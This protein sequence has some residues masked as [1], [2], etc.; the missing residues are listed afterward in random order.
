MIEQEKHLQQ[1]S[2]DTLNLFQKVSD[3]VS[4]KIPTSPSHSSDALAYSNEFT[5]KA[6]GRLS[7][8]SDANSAVLKKLKI[9]PA[10]SRVIFED[11][12]G[13]QH[14]VYITRVSTAGVRVGATLTSKNSKL[15]ALSSV[16][17][18]DAEF[19][20][21]QGKV[22]E[23]IVVESINLIPTQPEGIWD[24]QNSTYRH[25]E[26]GTLSIKSLR[27][28]LQNSKLKDMDELEAL[29][30]GDVAEDN[31][32]QGVAHQIRTAMG[33]RD[34]PIL[35]KF[36]SSIFRQ[37][38]NSQKIILGPPGTGKTT[39]LIQR[40]GQ[41]VDR[42]YL[43]PSEEN[44]ANNDFSG[45][46]HEQSWLMF[47]PTDLL[48][49]YVKE[50]FAREQ[51]PASNERI[52]TWNS[53]RDDIARNVFD[54]LVF[55]TDKG[56]FKKKEHLSLLNPNT[57]ANPVEWFEQLEK[58]HNTR[59]SKQLN[60]GLEQL[61]NIKNKKVESTVEQ[62]H[63][64]VLNSEPMNLA[65]T[66]SSLI[67]LEEKL[68]TIVDSESLRIEK[69]IKSTISTLY[70]NDKSILADLAKFF[71][72][73]STIDD[74]EG[75]E[76]DDDPTEQK[77]ISKHTPATAAKEYSKIIKSIARQ[78]YL[79]RSLSK[80]SRG[81]LVKEW[82]GSRL[83]SDDKLV[84][85]G[86]VVTFQNSLR[87]FISAHRRFITEIAASYKLFRK[88]SY[89]NNEFYLSVP[90]VNKDISH[91]E[92]DGVILQTL[93]NIHK[94]LK[95]K[96]FRINIE[97]PSF[98]YLKRR[99][100]V[101]KNQILV[102]EATDFSII[103]LACMKHLSHVDTQSFF[104]CGDFNQRL[105]S[106]GVHS[107]EQLKWIIP[108]TDIEII[109]AAYRQSRKLNEFAK[110][111]LIA[112][113]G[114]VSALGQIPEESN[115]NGVD[116][117]L[118][119]GYSNIT[120]V[121]KWLSERIIEIH[122]TVNSSISQEAVIVPTIAI[123]VNDESNVTLLADSLNPYLEEVSLTAEAC[124]DG[125]SLGEYQG[126]RVFSVE[127]IKGLE[128][129]AVFFIDVDELAN[130]HPDTFDK[131]LYV[132]VTRAAT[133]LGMTCKKELPIEISSLRGLLK[134]TF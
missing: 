64:I 131:F 42:E 81:F 43:E 21:F 39:T 37:P 127:H 134:A 19:I 48:K 77:T 98:S 88:E 47:T 54:L 66:Y 60:D 97:N 68:K 108:E 52:R 35:D 17:I 115:H 20:E 89:V 118:Y 106:S 94:L 45:L 75:D 82:L 5:D 111:L 32:E 53:V 123:L 24:S 12:K 129:E 36:Q 50:A 86:Q 103:Q 107:Q 63:R 73:L 14:T 125:K 130:Y 22:Q 67:P 61:K 76:F 26:L 91:L 18:G 10:I 69:L 25:E 2:D 132:G 30:A 109:T 27:A 62:L 116:P 56:A 65:D 121:A 1:L 11:E 38:L 8:I 120:D 40:L 104:A 41:K 74:S 51:V 55:G 15:G 113:S 114:D 71:D 83:P 79:K 44:L 122:E 92:L 9:E 84:E 72:G 110:E 101:L 99:A 6:H 119:E 31:I 28:L 96:V 85:I 70:S 95:Q 105:N 133:Y 117:V 4:D 87:R 100:G 126:V 23:L 29:L 102:D 59:L 128:F 46:S 90:S 13:S 112:T 58:F 7:A 16:P 3:H 49:H 34:Q 33:L 57:I 93:V 80:K 124:K 78:K